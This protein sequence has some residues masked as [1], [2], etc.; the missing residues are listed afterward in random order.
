MLRTSA[1]VIM[2]AIV[3]GPLAAQELTVKA[4]A[5][6]GDVSNKSLL[7]GTLGRRNGFAAGVGLAF[8]GMVGF[9]VEALMAQR[10]V[11]SDQ[12]AGERKLDYVDI[13]GYLRI[14]LPLPVVKPFVYAGPQVSIELRCRSGAVDCADGVRRKRTYAGVIGAGLQIM[15]LSLEGRYVYGVSDLKLGTVTS[16]ASFQTRSFMLLAGLRL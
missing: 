12:A 6:F 5:S 13:P 11:V 2:A 14:R 1:V 4:G 10:G 8:G 7:P 15:A 3:S 16:G 9:G